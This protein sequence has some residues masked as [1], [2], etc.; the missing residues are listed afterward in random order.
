LDSLLHGGHPA[1]APSPHL[2]AN[3]P[4]LISVILSTAPRPAGGSALAC[5][6]TGNAMTMYLVTSVADSSDMYFQLLSY[7]DKTLVYD[8]TDGGAPNPT[9]VMSTPLVQ[10]QRQRASHVTIQQ[11]EPLLY[12]MCASLPTGTCSLLRVATP[13]QA[14]RHPA[15]STP[16][17]PC[18]AACT[19][20]DHQMPGM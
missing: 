5:C 18:K 17:R 1:S 7:P 13:A 9:S 6:S 15:T 19:Y 16:G 11:P 14:P 20:L 4:S 10:L 3:C 12:S 8:S 2:L